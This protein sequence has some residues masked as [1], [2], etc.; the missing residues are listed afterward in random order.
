MK[1]RKIIL[2]IF[3]SMAIINLFGCNNQ[4]EKKT[5]RK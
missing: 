5:C 2:A 4:F 3:T 1:L